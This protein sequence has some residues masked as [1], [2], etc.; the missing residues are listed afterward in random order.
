[1]ISLLV[2]I[3]N[4]NSYQDTETVV[5]SI[6]NNICLDGYNVN[7]V[8]VDNSS[9]R[10]IQVETLKRLSSFI[11]F[12]V[13]DSSEGL[14]SKANYWVN[15]ENNGFGAANNIVLEFVEKFNYYDAIWILNNDL[16][17]DAKCLSS[18]KPYLLNDDFHIL[19]SIIVENNQTVF[20]TD[21]MESFKG[22]GYPSLE[23]QALDVYQV[24]A[25]VGTSMFLKRK[26]L[27]GLRFDENYFMYVE[28][29]D[30]CYRY[31]Q[32]GYF[33]SIVKA[34]KV[35]HESGKTF[36]DKQ[37]LR[38]YYK[39]RN[40]LYFKSKNQSKNILLIPYLFLSTVKQFKL[41]K[42]YLLAYFWGVFDFVFKIRGITYRSFDR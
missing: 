7:F 33:S 28:E 36:G 16:T 21:Y 9:N 37:A 22:Y 10:N 1:M 27:A 13:V 26:F 12:E 25:V 34:S 35:F 11:D 6:L 32:I 18:M 31:K 20:G 8:V 3:I 42:P 40:L 2:S 24:D 39:V 15:S 41:S 38:W 29:N 4:F 23:K 5:K 30:L 19:G 17:I 14:N